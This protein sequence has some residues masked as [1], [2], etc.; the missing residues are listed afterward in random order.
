MYAVIRI[1]GRVDVKKEIEDTLGMLRLHRVNH[2]V[3]VPESPEYLGMLR[4]LK[5]MVTWGE[6]DQKTAVK[7]FE[8]RGMLTG[9]KKL[10]EKMLKKMTKYDSFDKFVKDL[11]KGKVKLK[12]FPEIKPVFRLNPPRKGFKSTRRSYPKGD[13]G[14]RKDKINELLERMV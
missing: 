6:I 9:E 10:D 1:K 4:K 7:L 12:D 8:E 5:D 14:N 3:L 13:L 2:C 11:M